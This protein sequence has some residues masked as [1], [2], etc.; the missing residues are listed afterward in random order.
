MTLHQVMIT[1]IARL[2]EPEVA[3]I[4]FVDAILRFVVAVALIAVLIDLFVDIF[5]APVTNVL[6]VDAPITVTI[7]R[8]FD[9]VMPKS[10]KTC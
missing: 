4:R 1:D 3:E 7:I 9:A 2:T 8:V 10:L 5:V 6:A